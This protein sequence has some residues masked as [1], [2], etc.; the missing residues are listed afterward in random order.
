[1]WVAW[2]F[3]WSRL[4]GRGVRLVSVGVGFGG[5]DDL[6]LGCFGFV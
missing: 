5:F 4:V 3:G 2:R 6:I 1:M